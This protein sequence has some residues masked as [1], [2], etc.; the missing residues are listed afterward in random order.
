MKKMMFLLLAAVAIVPFSTCYGKRA[1]A[2]AKELDGQTVIIKHLGTG[3]YLRAAMMDDSAWMVDFPVLLS[4]REIVEELVEMA[5][6]GPAALAV[7]IFNFGNIY[8]WNHPNG[9]RIRKTRLVA[10]ADKT[11]A[12]KFKIEKKG[13]TRFVKILQPDGRPLFAEKTGLVTGKPG[14]AFAKYEV[15]FHNAL[16]NTQEHWEISG[17]SYNQCS[18][19]N[20]AND[21]FLTIPQ[22]EIFGISKKQPTKELRRLS[23]QKLYFKNGQRGN[24][25]F[26]RTSKNTAWTAM[27]GEDHR[28]AL[29]DVKDLE[30]EG[31]SI[32]PLKAR[33][34]FMMRMRVKTGKWKKPGQEP[35]V[36]PRRKFLTGK[37]PKRSTV[38]SNEHTA[39]AIEFLTPPMQP[40]K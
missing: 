1:M 19:K 30:K 6:I 4:I 9:D 7:D 20:R 2:F 34:G 38:R 13:L 18:L 40:A 25:V 28:I 24:M 5:M 10:D 17:N 8:A 12:T 26:S 11:N 27:A 36:Y 33:A 15:A 37:R 22:E 21:N 39:F 14:R 23:A 32:L 3:K 35:E 31:R 29:V 16:L